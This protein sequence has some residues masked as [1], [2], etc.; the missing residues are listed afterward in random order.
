MTQIVRHFTVTVRH[1]TVTVRHFK[2]I[3]PGDTKTKIIK[4]KV[5]KL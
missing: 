5:L 2:E 3:L 4:L 1:F